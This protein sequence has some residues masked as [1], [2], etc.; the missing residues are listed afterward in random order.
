MKLSSGIRTSRTSN[1]Q[2][3]STTPLDGFTFAAGFELLQECSHAL[4][5]FDPG[6]EL[7]HLSFRNFLPALRNRNRLGEAEEQ[8]PDLVQAKSRLLR[9]SHHRQPVEH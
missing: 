7:D 1:S 3:P 6:V 9:P 5:L 8:L 2:N 4:E